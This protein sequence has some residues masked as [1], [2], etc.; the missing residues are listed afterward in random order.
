MFQNFQTDVLS[1]LTGIEEDVQLIKQNT[2]LAA[3]PVDNVEKLDALTETVNEIRDQ[4][5]SGPLPSQDRISQRVQF[6]PPTL[7]AGG[8][9]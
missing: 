3:E 7:Q 4:I 1:R 9:Y 5:Q 2:L 8:E 6:N